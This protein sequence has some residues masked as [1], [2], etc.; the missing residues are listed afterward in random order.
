M[1]LA[2]GRCHHRC[3]ENSAVAAERIMPHGIERMKLK[4]SVHERLDQAPGVCVHFGGIP[5]SLAK[6]TEQ[7]ISM[8][9]VHVL[10][11]YV[12]LQTK[13]IARCRVVNYKHAGARQGRLRGGFDPPDN[14]SQSWLRPL[15]VHDRSPNLLKRRLY[16]SQSWL[17]PL[18][19]HDR[20]PGLLK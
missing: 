15:H 3:A 12:H 7:W 9:C 1:R 2:I 5:S 4:C 6:L 13:S 10:R 8:R 19:V 14:V 20:S 18:R 17:R 11:I 16:M